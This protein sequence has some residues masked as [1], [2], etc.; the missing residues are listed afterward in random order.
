MVG[1]RAADVT[2]HKKIE[3]LRRP[4]DGGDQPHG[5]MGMIFAARHRH[6][7][8][9]CAT[10]KT[11]CRG[12]GTQRR[13]TQRGAARRDLTSGLAF[14]RRQPLQPAGPTSRADWDRQTAG[15]VP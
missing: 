4:K 5:R 11:R 8:L 9:T 6:C 10:G 7:S 1:V 12:G 15:A 14:A 13:S 2:E 3:P